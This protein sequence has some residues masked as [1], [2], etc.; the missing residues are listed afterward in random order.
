MWLRPINRV[1]A[2]ELTVVC[3]PH[4]G[5]A[6][7][8]FRPWGPAAPPGMRL[9]AVQ[10]PGREDRLREP[11]VTDLDEL[12]DLVTAALHRAGLGGALL[13]GH[14]L[15]AAVAYEVAV[16]LEP[17][18]RGLV[19]SGRPGPAA[20]RHTSMHASSDETLCAE[21]LRLNGTPPEVLAVGELRR[22]ILGIIRSDYQL[23]ET[24]RRTR[25]PGP[26]PTLSCPVLAC[27][28]SEDTEVS[29]AEAQAW[30]AVTGAGFTR[31]AL[32]GDHFYLTRH[33]RRILA[34]IERISWRCTVA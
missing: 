3:F 6:A 17:D 27:H 16:R 14:S 10:Y 33:Q 31:L 19:V 26:V 29:A 18:V 7:T 25:Q 11:P 28:G 4:A 23:S 32:P 15:G 8:F 34:E 30:S 9:V 13:F 5:G 24:W 21:L 2:P 12:A 22:L 20:D 1:V